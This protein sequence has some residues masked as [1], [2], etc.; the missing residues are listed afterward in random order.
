MR[1]KEAN[2]NLE[3]SGFQKSS[4]IQATSMEI[5]R[6]RNTTDKGGN[7][8][9]DVDSISI[10]ETGRIQSFTEYYFLSME[11]IENAEKIKSL[12]DEF[13]S[14]EDKLK[15]HLIEAFMSRWLD[16]D[17]KMS[18]YTLYTK[19]DVHNEQKQQLRKLNQFN[20]KKS[21]VESTYFKEGVGENRTKQYQI[22]NTQKID[23]K[24][25]H[26]R[27][28]TKEQEI[29]FS[30]K[31]KVILED[32]KEIDVDYLMHLS[33]KSSIRSVEAFSA[34]IMIDPIVITYKGDSTKLTADKYAFDIDMDGNKDQISFATKG[35]GFLALDKNNNGQ[36][37]DG[38]ELFGPSTNN[39]FLE[40]A[41]YDEDNNGW[42]DEN[43]AVFNQL[44]I[45]ERLDDGTTKLMSLGEV[46]IGALYLKDI[47]TLFD[48]SDDELNAQ[49]KMKTSSIY[50]NE[51]GTA[52]S[53]HEIDIVV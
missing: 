36:I 34:S 5:K 11:E 25:K 1:I 10:S 29:N 44:R 17:F 4:V 13:L 18:N 33:E 48:I 23:V 28:E 49:G 21:L 43:D 51:D 14:E 27:E 7:Q 35:S 22:L 2:M 50:L 30:A 24:Y 8:I 46:G 32:G 9:R 52:G 38:K 3:S 37:D 6:Q 26:Y 45:W 15:I 40:L 47:T 12:E 31:G 53:I 19:S 42:I 16:K 39:G 41:A 20:K